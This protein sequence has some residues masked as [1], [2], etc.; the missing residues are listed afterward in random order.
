MWVN[1]GC[2]PKAQP[3]EYLIRPAQAIVRHV[4]GAQLVSGLLISLLEASDRGVGLRL[5]RE[6]AVLL[7]GRRLVFV[8]GLDFRY[9]S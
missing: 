8:P 3:K 1:S 4:A 9:S 7:A 2:M 5:A 6:V